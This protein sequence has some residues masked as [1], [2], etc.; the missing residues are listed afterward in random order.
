MM[1]SIQTG[2]FTSNL[3]PVYS[4]H[5]GNIMKRRTTVTLRQD[6]YERLKSL[7]RMGE[8]F[9]TVLGRILDQVEGKEKK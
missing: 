4:G 5:S 8:S 2:N 9:N 1:A 7:G 6:N 3:V